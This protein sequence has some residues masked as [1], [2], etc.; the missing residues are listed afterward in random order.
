MDEIELVIEADGSVRFVYAD[1]VAELFAGEKATTRRASHVEPHKGGWVADMTPVCQPGR[2]VLV[3]LDG[4]IELFGWE[5]GPKF[6]WELVR[7]FARRQDALA[8][9]IAWIRNAM[10]QGVVGL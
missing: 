1:D 9:E 5:T 2:G 7:P 8:A 4:V 10:A 3:G 6:A